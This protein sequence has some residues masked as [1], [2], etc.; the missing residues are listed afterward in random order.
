MKKELPKQKRSI[1]PLTI[2]VIIFI[3][4]FGIIVIGIIALI[5]SVRSGMFTNQLQNVTCTIFRGECF[6]V[7]KKPIIYL[8]PI[9][10]EEVNVK[11]DYQGKIIADYPKY[12]ES[13][14]G[15]NVTAYPD[16]H[17]INKS[18]GKEYSYL[19]WEGKSSANINWDLSKGFVVKGEDTR[20]FLS[21]TLSKMGLTPKEYNEFIV[22]WYPLMK[23]NPYN[24]IHFAGREYTDTAPL[25]ITPKPDSMLRVF[26]VYK[27]LQD[28]IDITPQDI[29]SFERKGF[30]VVEWGA[31]KVE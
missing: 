24:L 10:E 19:F 4:I 20:E 11:L 17:L 26:M 3:S 22:Y 7:M 21:Q 28:K 16:G 5:V 15:W 12:D 27:A 30:S 25:N 2:F 1:T 23:D 9:K 13:T 6:P 8:Y 29:G 14:N 31:T 18:D